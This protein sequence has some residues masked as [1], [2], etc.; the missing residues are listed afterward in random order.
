MNTST[1]TP[2]VTLQAVFA[3]ATTTVDGGWN[4][5]LSVDASQAKDILALAQ[6]RDTVLQCAFVPV[7]EEEF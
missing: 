5:T 4:I 3:K 2:G 6:L 7:P 1:D